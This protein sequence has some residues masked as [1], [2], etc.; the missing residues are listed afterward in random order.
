MK[1]AMLTRLVLVLAV[2]TGMSSLGFQ[3]SSPNITS[4]KMYYQ[5]YESSKDPEKLDK[6]LEAFQKEVTEKPNSAEGWYWLGFIQGVK[7]EY[8]EMEKSWKKSLNLSPAKKSDID[9]FRPMFW[10][11]AFNH[12]ALTFKKAQTYKKV[13]PKEAAELYREAEDAF[14]AAT[15]L[16]PDSSAKY[17]GYL[18]LAYVLMSEER[19]S[20]AK[21]PLQEQIKRH[22]MP[23]AYQG[24][25]QLIVSEA[26]DLKKA[27]DT[28]AADAKYSEALAV[29]N[30]G[31]DKFPDDA[32][33]NNE[34]LNTYIAANR[35]TE[36]V[37]K[38]KSFADNNQKDVSAQ[39]AA[40]TALLQIKK[41]EDAVTYLERALAID[42][43]HESALYNICVAYLRWGID[44]RDQDTSTDPDA[45]HSDYKEVI[46]KA[47]PHMQ[48]LLEV[49]PDNAQNWD[50]AGKLFAS[51]GMTKEAQDAYEKADSL[52]K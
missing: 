11:Q 41:Y 47:V 37:E 29:L 19:W 24:L 25:A 13:K 42:P 7:K 40:G 46:K 4:G 14:R 3:C 16:E 52:K 43:N 22:A 32:N 35:V 12:G 27:G 21:E 18:N 48:H 31:L 8:G 5:Q 50:L 2:V 30:E 45:Q 38:F 34:L 10:G 49:A 6:A 15:L 26:G 17:G 23:E 1:Q 36:A 33:L 39:Y 44:I 28:E 51:V 20:D 9:Q